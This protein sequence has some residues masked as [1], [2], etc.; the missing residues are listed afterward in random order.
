M[1]RL[2]DHAFEESGLFGRL[3][4]NEIR[5]LKSRASSFDQLSR[6]WIKPMEGM[7]KC[8]L[9]ASWINP[10]SMI[11]GAWIVR[12]SAGDVVDHARDI[13]IASYSR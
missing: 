3:K 1:N 5:E 7:V 2:V 13:F 6:H 11:D 9:Y 8:N 12:N 10:S 4:D